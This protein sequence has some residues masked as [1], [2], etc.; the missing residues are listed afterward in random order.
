MDV[1]LNPNPGL[2]AESRC[3]LV[4]TAPTYASDKGTDV[5]L[6]VVLERAR[7]LV[8]KW[9]ANGCTIDTEVTCVGDEVAVAG[10]SVSMGALCGGFS[11]VD[12]L[13]DGRLSLALM[14]RVAVAEWWT[15]MMLDDDDDDGGS[16]DDSRDGSGL[17]AIL[18]E[19]GRAM[20]GPALPVEGW[21]LRVALVEAL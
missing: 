2:I 19:W 4:E 16:D 8:W 13:A 12:W 14:E 1:S 9:D 21:L 10:E 7:V 11:C 6:F 17:G 3:E 15:K 5:S 20:F 18:V